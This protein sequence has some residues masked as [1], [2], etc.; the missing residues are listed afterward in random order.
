MQRREMDAV[1]QFRQHRRRDQLV[2]HK[3]RAAMH[4]TMP[5]RDRLE[6]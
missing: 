4:H 1:L 5:N 6:L 3:M 2:S